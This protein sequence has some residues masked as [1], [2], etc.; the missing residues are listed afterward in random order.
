MHPSI[1]HSPCYSAGVLALQEQRLGLAILEAE[2]LGVASDVE[3]ALLMLSAYCP[4]YMS[5]GDRRRCENCGAVVCRG[6]D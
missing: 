5:C 6:M 4:S 1:Q 3:F 2:D